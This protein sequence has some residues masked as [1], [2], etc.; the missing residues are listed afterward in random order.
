LGCA[1]RADPMGVEPEYTILPFA[2]QGKKKFPVIVM[3]SGYTTPVT[4]D[5]KRNNKTVVINN[6]LFI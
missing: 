1:I 3:N 4:I 6:P 5:I 2:F